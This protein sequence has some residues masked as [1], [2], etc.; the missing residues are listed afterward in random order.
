MGNVNLMITIVDRKQIKRYYEL[1]RNNEQYVMFISL[2]H[3]TAKNEM[4]NYLGLDASNK[5]VIYSVVTE[6]AWLTLKQQMEYRLWIDSY[7]DGISFIIPLESIGGKRTMH[8]LLETEESPK[9]EEATLKETTHSL[10]ITIAEQGYTNQIMD[11]ARPAGA[12]GGTVFHAKGTGSE[13]AQKFLGVSLAEEKEIL[14][15]VTRKE[16]KNDIMRAIH[17]QAGPSTKAK[18][19]CFSLP[20]TDTAGLTFSEDS[21]PKSPAQ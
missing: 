5:T 8:Y 9:Q 13:M 11:A 15:I 3:G 2:A 19:I 17:E 18:A 10:I 20:V 14:Y 16:K 7:G 4:L 21:L 1:Y 6:N 12:Y